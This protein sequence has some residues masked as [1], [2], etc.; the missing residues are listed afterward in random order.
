MDISLFDV[1][2]PIMIGPSS[3]H[4]AGAARLAFVAREIAGEFTHVTFG[5]HG[6]FAQTYKGHGTDKALV[7]GAL[8]LS[9]QDERLRHSFEMADA[10]GLTYEFYPTHIE[11]AHEN[12]VLMTFSSGTQPPLEVVGSSLGGGRIL[13]TRIGEYAAEITADAPTLVIVQRDRKGMVSMVSHILASRGINIGVMRL[14]RTAK[15]EVACCVIE[16][17]GALPPD[18]VREI[19]QVPDVLS[20]R[21]IDSYT[22]A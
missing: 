6:S 10:V 5:L 3:S 2:G 11:G 7:A 9:A 20:V 14:S 4:T 15:G 13:I 16:T 22:M 19:A 17:D 18:A 21:A 1:V 8:G 12:T